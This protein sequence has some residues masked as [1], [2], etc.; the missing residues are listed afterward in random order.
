MKITIFYSWQSDLPNN[1]NRGYIKRILDKVCKDIY[2]SNSNISEIV[3]DSDSRDESGT[4]DLVS[5]IFTKI[6]KCNI[7]IADISIINSDLGLRKTPNPNVLIELG[8]ASG[9]I[10]WEKY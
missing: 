8:Y 4:P 9:K 2:S 1:T 6:D 7:F 10:G 5:T 3:I